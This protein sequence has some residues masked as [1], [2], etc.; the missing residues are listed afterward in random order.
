LVKRIML[1]KSFLHPKVC[2][3]LD[4]AAAKEAEAEAEKAAKAA[5]KAQAAENKEIKEAEAQE[6]AS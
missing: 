4:Y 2:A 3:A 1:R 5:K 6:R